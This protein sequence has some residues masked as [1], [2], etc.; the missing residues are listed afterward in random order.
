VASK[1]DGLAQQFA[2][3]LSKSAT[4]GQVH[5]EIDSTSSADVR[6]IVEGRLSRGAA[7]SRLRGHLVPYSLHADARRA[8]LQLQSRRGRR[9]TW[10]DVA[11]EGLALLLEQ[12]DVA[13]RRLA[14]IRRLAGTATSPPRLV[15]ATISTELD[16]S[17]GQFRLELSHSIGTDVTYE[18]LWAAA[19]LLWVRENR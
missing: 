11:I 13:P 4:R 14:D 8:K 17:L 2:E 19:L 15:Q 12:R 10:D 6:G 18:Q 3:R 1:R 16:Q 7:G 9:I 5:V